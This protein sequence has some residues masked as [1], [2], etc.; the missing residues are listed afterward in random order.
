MANV[1][2]YV[3]GRRLIVPINVLSAVTVEL[4]D[5]MFQDDEDDLRNDGDSTANNYGYPIEYF[6]ISGSSVELNRREL[7]DHFIGVAMDDKD[8]IDDGSDRNIS[9]A[10]SGKFNFDLKPGKTVRLSQMFEASGTTAASNMLNQKIAQTTNVDSALGYF[11][12]S[13]SHARSADVFIRTK[14]RGGTI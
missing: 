9:V 4:G 13:K 10:T 6:R 7:K 8:G 1:Q 14:F 12:E 2:R 3:D 5:L 11:A